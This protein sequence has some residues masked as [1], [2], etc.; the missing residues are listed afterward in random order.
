VTHTQIFCVLRFLTRTFWLPRIS[1]FQ[2]EGSWTEVC[3]EVA[4][5]PVRQSVRKLNS[6]S[7]ELSSEFDANWCRNY[8]H[9]LNRKLQ[10][11]FH[12]TLPNDSI[13]E[14]LNSVKNTSC[15]IFLSVV[16][17]LSTQRSHIESLTIYEQRN[18]VSAIF[19][20]SH[21]VVNKN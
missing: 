3:R 14:Q 7:T 17:I 1:R 4:Q 2:D 20:P 15:Y 13:I 10:H 12:K 9:L 6:H 8:L 11:L 5:V 16:L 21:L 19:L 18:L